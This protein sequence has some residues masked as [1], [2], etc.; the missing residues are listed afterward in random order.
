MPGERRLNCDLR[1]LDVANFSDH[2]FVGIMPQNRSK[3]PCEGKALLLIHG[4]LRDA[5]NLIFDRILD[6]ENF[7]FFVL[8][9]HQCGIKRSRL[10]AAGWACDEH[11][12]VWF[13]DIPAEFFDIGVGKTHDLEAQAPKFF[14]YGLFVENTDYSI[15]AM[16]RRHDGD[17]EIYGPAFISR[18]EPAVLRNAP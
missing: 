16:D 2:D 17:A 1:R 3:S 9:L 4:Y 8:D 7:V 11:H 10:S 18:L 14:A 13:T 6:S 5:A 12:A 15:L